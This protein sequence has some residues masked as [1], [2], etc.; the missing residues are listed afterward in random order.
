MRVTAAAFIL[1]CAI[2]CWSGAANADRTVCR[3]SSNSSK[4]LRVVVPLERREEFIDFLR[5]EERPI[6][7]G[8][9]YVGGAEDDESLTICFLDV[10]KQGE[11]PRIDICAENLASSGVFD[12]SFHTCNTTISWEP[13]FEAT[14]ARVSSLN[15]VSISEVAAE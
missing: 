6:A 4:L 15:Y 13:Y 8:A 5:S 7:L 12:F 10:P 14:R 1:S 3:T 2:V 9:R 11:E